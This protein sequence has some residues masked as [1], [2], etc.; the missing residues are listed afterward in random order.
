MASFPFPVD[1]PG[2]RPEDYAVA[3]A[4][5]QGDP[6]LRFSIAAPR[7]WSFQEVDPRVEQ[8][9]DGLLW[10]ACLSESPGSEVRI[11][12]ACS[13]PQREVHPADWL[14]LALAVGGESLQAGRRLA[15]PGGDAGDALTLREND[16]RPVVSR[17]MAFKAGP[18]IFVVRGSAPAE[19]YA[20]T[21][22]VFFTAFGSF[23]L[24]RPAA[25]PYCE[26]MTEHV[27]EAPTP[28]RFLVPASWSDESVRPLPGCA[29][30]KFLYGADETPGGSGMLFFSALPHTDDPAALDEWALEGLRECGATLGGDAVA[31]PV[32]NG[33]LDGPRCRRFTGE[34]QGVPLDIRL[35]DGSRPEGRW[36]VGVSGPA[37]SADRLSWMVN[38]RAFD[39]A[40]ATLGSPVAPEEPVDDGVDYLAV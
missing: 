1:N 22:E 34:A 18:H 6:A 26:A 19:R 28:S 36:L 32:R 4:A 11:D 13:A 16:G 29:S 10:L 5:A 30:A 35:F 21:A 8:P 14:E 24:L 12:V 17:T 20:A 2:Y 9:G 37:K 25:E 3:E 27:F 23:R 7:N 40:V 15:H 39:I 38:V 33:W 31:E